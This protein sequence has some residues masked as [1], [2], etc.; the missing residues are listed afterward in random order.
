MEVDGAE[1]QASDIHVEN[2]AC[3]DSSSGRI[4]STS[5]PHARDPGSIPSA[6]F[7]KL[8]SPAKHRWSTC[9][10]LYICSA[11]YIHTHNSLQHSTPQ[12]HSAVYAVQY[13]VVLCRICSTACIRVQ[14]STAV[15]CSICSAAYV[16]LTAQRRSTGPYNAVQSARTEYLA[17]YSTVQHSHTAQ[18]STARAIP[19]SHLLALGNHLEN[20]DPPPPGLQLISVFDPPGIQRLADDHAHHL[21]RYLISARQ[22]RL[23]AQNLSHRRGHDLPW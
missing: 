5:A 2:Q 3:A 20:V 8:F 9:N 10:A 7:I 1:K 21:N 4:Q 16:V 18:C 15:Q 22:A 12:Q 17:Q 6:G 13:N 23:G 14:Y 11:V 19:S